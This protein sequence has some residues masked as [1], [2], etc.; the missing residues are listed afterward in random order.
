MTMN[1]N[2]E[3]AKDAQRLNQDIQREATELAHKKDE[4][5]EMEAHTPELRQEILRLKQE[6]EHIKGEIKRKEDELKN[7][8]SNAPRYRSEISRL[9]IDLRE[10]HR[11]LDEA[12]RGSIEA[13]KA[14]GLK[15]HLK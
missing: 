7:D 11:H 10:K 14:A 1:S 5:K 15:I 3:F 13:A 12:R 2:N 8:A 4:L 6:A 9:E